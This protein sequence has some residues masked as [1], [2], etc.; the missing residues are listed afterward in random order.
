MALLGI[1]PHFG[2]NVKNKLEQHKTAKPRAHSSWELWLVTVMKFQHL[3]NYR[4]H[5]HHASK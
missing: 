2:E 5:I 4:Y 3:S 1:S